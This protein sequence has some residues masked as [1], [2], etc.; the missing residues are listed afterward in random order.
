MGRLGGWQ[1]ARVRLGVKLGVWLEQIDWKG[2]KMW[3]FGMYCNFMCGSDSM[4]L[5]RE[6]AC[7]LPTSS[8]SLLK[9]R[10]SL[11]LPVIEINPWYTRALS[12]SLSVS[13]SIC[14]YVTHDFSSHF[15]AE[16]TRIVIQDNK[17]REY[18][19]EADS[20]NPNITS[21][22]LCSA[23]LS[24]LRQ[25][26]ALSPTSFGTASNTAHLLWC[27]VDC[28]NT[29]GG[30][31]SAMSTECDGEWVQCSL[32]QYCIPPSVYFTSL[33]DADGM[34]G[35][36]FLLFQAYLCVVRFGC[37]D[38]EMIP[39]YIFLDYSFLY[40]A[41]LFFPLPAWLFLF[42]WCVAPHTMWVFFSNTCM[43][44][45]WSFLY[46]S[47]SKPSWVRQPCLPTLGART[48]W[49]NVMASSF[50]RIYNC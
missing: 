15:R 17:N 3:Q 26:H 30:V 49:Q 32:E 10:E 44:D 35:L 21:Q 8:A 36:S 13:L 34:L 50:G 14:I 46:V 7:T 33:S 22:A 38:A 43:Y 23:W 42:Q 24:R 6:G 45:V 20:H 1:G 48:N 11:F 31:A 29:E 40:S 19:F 12:L 5:Y 39:F 37:M 47:K 28:V 27:W 9:K 4:L 25:T 2:R 18:N 41:R 16:P